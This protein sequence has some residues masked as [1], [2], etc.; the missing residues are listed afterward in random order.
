LS[1][2][3]IPRPEHNAR[4]WIEVCGTSPSAV[5]ITIPDERDKAGT[6]DVPRKEEMWSLL[7]VAGVGSRAMKA[8]GTIE[9][10]A[11]EKLIAL[12]LLFPGIDIDSGVQKADPQGKPDAGERGNRCEGDPASHRTT[13]FSQT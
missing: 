11:E 4:D 2:G 8:D 5:S 6:E 10:E 12:H 7:A 1:S 9:P 13:Y 3:V